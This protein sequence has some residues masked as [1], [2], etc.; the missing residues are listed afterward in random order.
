MDLSIIIVS[1]QVKDRLEENLRALY[2]SEG[3]FKF[4]VFVV[5][6]ASKDDSAQMIRTK[7]PQVNLIANL[8]NLGF[9]KANNQAIAKSKGE[10]ILLL[11]PDMKVGP[12]TLKLALAFAKN[13][14][15]AT[16]SGIRLVDAKGANVAHVRRFPKFF[17]QLMI[18]LKLP[19]LFPGLL[20]N[21][22]LPQFNYN[23]TAKV[24]S[25]R[26]SFFLINRQ[27]FMNISS[28]RIP[29]LDE[30][31]F[32]WFEEVDFCRYVYS[33]GGEVWYNAQATCQDDVGQSF[34]LIS[35]PKAQAYFKDSMLKYFAKWE[36]KWQRTLLA[37]AWRLVSVVIR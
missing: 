13:K 29:Y 22:L 8:K 31:Y 15:Q 7:F 9:A 23:N 5:D 2:A 26:G 4:E 30:R 33:L 34:A 27:S 6:N 20:K 3:D 1:W 12:D 17:D 37:W 18:V 36:P 19:H 32:V 24:D 16:V 14:E 35:R 21:Y 28:G 10:F 11:N 25:V